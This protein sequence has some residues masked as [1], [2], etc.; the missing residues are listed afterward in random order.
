MSPR[1]WCFYLHA[2]RLFLVPDS[3]KSGV[4]LQRLHTEAFHWVSCPVPHQAFTIGQTLMG[5]WYIREVRRPGI[6][7]LC[8]TC[9]S[10]K[11]NYLSLWASWIGLTELSASVAGCASPQPSASLSLLMCRW[12]GSAGPA[13]CWWLRL[14]RTTKTE[15]HC[16]ITAGFAAVDK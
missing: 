15:G 11:N 14:T 1:C 16:V 4:H 3:R 2:L 13:S 9:K 6:Q 8:D 5:A 12:L 10:T 7:L